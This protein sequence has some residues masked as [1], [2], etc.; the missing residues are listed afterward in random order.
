MVQIGPHP[1]RLR[2]LQKADR[3]ILAAISAGYAQKYDKRE[4]EP[5]IHRTLMEGVESA[6]ALMAMGL[7]RDDAATL[8]YTASGQPYRRYQSAFAARH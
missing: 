1:S 5:G 4:P 2:H 8:S 7:A 6:L 3:W